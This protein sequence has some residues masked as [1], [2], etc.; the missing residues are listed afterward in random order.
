LRPVDATRRVLV[1]GVGGGAV[2][3]LCHELL[4]PVTVI[5]VDNC[6]THL[7]IARRFFGVT[8][9]RAK[10][11]H[12]D[13]RAWLD[14]YAGPPFDFVI[15]DLFGETAGEPVRALPADRHW[16]ETLTTHLTP[17]GV[18]SMNFVEPRELRDAVNHVQE[19]PSW[20]LENVFRLSLPN[21]EN[22]IGAFTRRAASARGLRAGLKVLS[23]ALARSV[24]AASLR[25]RRVGPGVGGRGRSSRRAPTATRDIRDLDGAGAQSR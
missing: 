3:R 18:L 11:V 21:Y 4:A 6:A 17:D 1:L 19:N 7:R 25:V 12:A 9:G 15:D 14:R 22:V 8:D 20:G 24:A 2:I 10:L 23:P 13:A 16:L 5:G